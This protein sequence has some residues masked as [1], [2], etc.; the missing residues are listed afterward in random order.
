[1]YGKEKAKKAMIRD[2]LLE[3]YG[4]RFPNH[5]LSEK[6]GKPIEFKFDMVDAVGQ[7]MYAC[8]LKS[9]S[10]K[11]SSSM[12]VPADVDLKKRSKKEDV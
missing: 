1:M 2:A 9:C 11:F 8:H 6:T 5:Q 10:S 7:V 4:I 3:R 12:I